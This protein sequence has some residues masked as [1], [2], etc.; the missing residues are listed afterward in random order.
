[1]TQ[2]LRISIS[3]WQPAH[4]VHPPL[5]ILA[6]NLSC[7]HRVLH[8]FVLA[9]HAQPRRTTRAGCGCK[10]GSGSGGGG[11]A[12]EYVAFPSPV[13]GDRVGH[14]EGLIDLRDVKAGLG[15]ELDEMAGGG[16][17]SCYR[18]LWQGGDRNRYC[19]SSRPT[20]PRYSRN[21]LVN[22]PSPHRQA[23]DSAL[24]TLACQEHP[25]FAPYTRSTG[26]T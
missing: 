5:P 15:I 25:L 22:G 9:L 8:C 24:S 10:L 7:T 12:H 4:Q 11:H 16:V 3:L 14:T 6:S 23:P 18:L 17:R 1:M 19:R 20:A 13:C 2:N 26:S 21:G